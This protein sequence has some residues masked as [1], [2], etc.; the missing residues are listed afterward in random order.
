MTQVPGDSDLGRFAGC[1]ILLAIGGGIAAFKSASVCSGLVQAG[2]DVQVAMT[3]SATE[4]LGSATFAALSGNPVG[5]TGID[6]SRFPLGPHIEL[7]RD[8][9]L[10]VV[11]PATAN[12]IGKFAGGIAD[13]LVSTLYL[14]VSCPVLIAPAMSDPMWK[15]ASVIRNVQQLVDDGCHIVGPEP[16]W[17]SCRVQGEG[18]MS[19]PESI[20]D[21]ASQLLTS[22]AT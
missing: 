3:S 19:E 8:V 4:F 21:A 12:L 9:Q 18:R 14:Q 6:S 22:T 2:A 1:R 17:L 5:V 15:K 13:C 10:M 7:A 11:A 16:G 20:L